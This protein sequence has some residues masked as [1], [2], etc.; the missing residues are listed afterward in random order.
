MSEP[1]LS[2]IEDY[3][4]LSGEKRKVVFAVIL[5]GL[6]IGGIYTAAKFYYGDVDDEIATEKTIANIPIR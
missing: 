1:T 6:I 5:S 4:T 3:N 2:A